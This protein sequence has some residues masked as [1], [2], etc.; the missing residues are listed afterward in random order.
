M[1]GLYQ[2]GALF[3]AL[4]GL[5]GGGVAVSLGGWQWAFLMWIPIGIATAVLIARQPEPRRGD[6]DADFEADMA[7]AIALNEPLAGTVEAVTS[8]LPTPR[9]VGTLD[10]ENCSHR[11][12]GRE[13]L[14]IPTLWFGVLALTV[15]Q[16]LL[17]GLQFWGVPYF[18]RVHHMGAAAAG[19]IASLLGLGAVVGIVGGGFLADRY[20]KRGIINS[21]VYVVGFGSIAATLFI[22]PAFAS[23]SLAVTA[24]LLVLGGVFRRCRWRPPRRSSPTSSSPSSGV[25]RQ[26]FVPL[27]APS[28]TS[29]RS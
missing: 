3:G 17:V 15:S 11:D 23:R 18:K 26:A 14:R 6:Q 27:S 8:L 24:P 21:R 10:Y 20:L 28:P 5:I 9:R 29:A 12:V 4:I 2:S 16:L 25:G 7:E 1:M 19:G 22:M 13:L